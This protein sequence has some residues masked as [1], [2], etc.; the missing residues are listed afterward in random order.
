MENTGNTR[1]DNLAETSSEKSSE[2]NTE[3]SSKISSETLS[4]IDIEKEIIEKLPVIKGYYLVLG[5]GKIGTDFLEYALENKFPFVLVIDSDE[6]APASKKAKVLANEEELV[7]LLRSNPESLALGWDGEPETYF[8]RADVHKIPYILSF[9]IPEYIV[10]AVPCHTA[11]YLTVDFLKLPLQKILVK[12]KPPE[13]GSQLAEVFSKG[14]GQEEEGL[15]REL[16][17]KDDDISKLSFFEAVA[18]SF[19]KSVLA[20]KYPEHGVLFFSYARPGEICPEDCPGPEGYCPN[21]D[22][23]KPKTIT[24]Y[25]EELA[26]AFQGWVFESCQMKPGIGGIRGRDLKADLLEIAEFVKE[27]LK[28][29]AENGSLQALENRCFFVATTCTCHGVLNLFHVP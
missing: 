23:E 29:R 1:S 24:K 10:P 7:K 4:E 20:G 26:P 5:G 21:F 22:R 2:I 12:G 13:T 9:G 25:A 17:I 16:F 18:A 19:P 28:E 27:L 6:N 3:N 8:Y 15:V 14:P 11:A